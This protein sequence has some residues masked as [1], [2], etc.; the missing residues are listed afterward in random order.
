MAKAVGFTPNAGRRI[1]AAV[2]TVEAIDNR[3]RRLPRDIRAGGGDVSFWAQITGSAEI[4]TTG[5][6]KY[7][8]SEQERTASGWQAKTGGRSGTT[9]SGYAITGRDFVVTGSNGPIV[10]MY[11]ET[12]NAGAAC[13]TFEIPIPP[14][15]A[16]YQGL[17]W[18]DGEWKIDY[19]R[20]HA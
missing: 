9:S 20:L 1:A 4:G 10:R 19:A 16:N 14:G 13:Y 2:R 18:V 8:W 12:D 7:A 17:Y 6:F 15:T 5:K 11:P 3:G